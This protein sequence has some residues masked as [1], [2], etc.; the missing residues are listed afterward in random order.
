M[1]GSGQYGVGVKLHCRTNSG[2]LSS[3]STYLNRCALSYL[4]GEP[5]LHGLARKS[6]FLGIPGRFP[7]KRAWSPQ[8]FRAMSTSEGAWLFPVRKAALEA[9]IA[10]NEAQA[11]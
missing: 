9:Y 2:T 3:A 1:E 5:S 6:P 4:L 7:P 8:L 11:K 10:M